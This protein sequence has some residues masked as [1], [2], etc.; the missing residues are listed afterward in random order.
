MSA[1]PIIRLSERYA[2]SSS[3]SKPSPFSSV[4]ARASIES[5]TCPSCINFF[6]RF[7]L[8]QTTCS[9]GGCRTH[10][11]PLLAKRDVA[12][13]PLS[14]RTLPGLQKL[15]EIIQ[16]GENIDEMSSRQRSFTN[17]YVTI[18]LF[19]WAYPRFEPIPSLHLHQLENSGPKD[20]ITCHGCNALYCSL[21]EALLGRNSAA[22]RRC[23]CTS[24]SNP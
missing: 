6:T 10:L 5:G 8:R 24:Q 17:Q 4:S 1:A 3:V 7:P 16:Q 18:R 13:E 23:T 9:L 11:H 20:R 15:W 22:Q 12:P 21:H 14:G 2:A 19:S